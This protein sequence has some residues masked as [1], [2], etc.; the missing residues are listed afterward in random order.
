MASKLA[1]I[2]AEVHRRMG[3][4]ILAEGFIFAMNDSGLLRLIEATPQKYVELAQARVLKGRESWAPLALAD[5]KLL[6]RDQSRMLCVKVT[7]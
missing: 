2:T 7:K 5:G 6:I 4:F 1:P 3:N